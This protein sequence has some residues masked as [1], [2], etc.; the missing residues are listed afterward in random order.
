MRFRRTLPG[1]T[2]VALFA[3]IPFFPKTNAAEARKLVYGAASSLGNG[4]IRTYMEY[5]NG[6]PVELGVEL[7]E[8]AMQ[9][10]PHHGFDPATGAHGAEFVLELPKDNPTPFKHA[11]VQWNPGGHEPPGIYDLPHFDFHF[12]T[13]DNAARLAMTPK[14]PAF[15]QEGGQPAPGRVRAGWLHSSGSGGDSHHGCA[16]DRPQV[17]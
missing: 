6:R 5:D 10:L 16:L 8:A 2:A 13:I 7:T 12:Y 3:T 4:S 11:V 14:D 17:A 15:E 9:N 1:F